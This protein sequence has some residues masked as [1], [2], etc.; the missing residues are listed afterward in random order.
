IW[1]WM[2]SLFLAWVPCAIILVFADY[3]RK[4]FGERGLTA[5]ERLMG[6]ILTTM[7]VQMFLTGVKGFFH[8]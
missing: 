2:L 8:L 6:M 1:L 3:L 4:I 7:A 5:I